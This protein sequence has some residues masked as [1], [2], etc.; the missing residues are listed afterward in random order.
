[1]EELTAPQAPA[2]PPPEDGTPV[3][4]GK[5]HMA[6]GAT[7]RVSGEVIRDAVLDVLRRRGLG[8]EDAL[9]V[10]EEVVQVAARRAA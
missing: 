10:A 2:P 8:E 3:V 6:G 1:M 5:A 7:V 9:A 4:R